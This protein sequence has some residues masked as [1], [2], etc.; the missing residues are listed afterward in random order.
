MIRAGRSEA[1]VVLRVDPAARFRGADLAGMGT[2]D[3]FAGEGV[4]PLSAKNEE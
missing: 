2:A 4:A 3:L 1:V